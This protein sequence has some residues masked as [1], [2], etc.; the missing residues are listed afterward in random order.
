MLSR[1]PA[2]AEIIIP[3]G[4][5][6]GA[7]YHV[8]NYNGESFPNDITLL[9]A[10]KD[11]V[12]TVYAQAADAVGPSNI[13]AMG[14]S[15]GIQ[16]PLP[17]NMSLVLGTTEVSVLDMAD[18][19]STFMDR[20]TNVSPSVIEEVRDANGKLMEATAPTLT[21]PL[22]ASQADSVT[23]ALQQVVLSGTGTGAQIGR[24]VAGKTGT[25]ESYSD[26]WFIG[27]TPHLT[28]AVWMGYRDAKQPMLNVHGVKNV[29]GGSLPADIFRRFMSGAVV[30]AP[31]NFPR[32]ASLSGNA[33][34]APPVTLVT[35]STSSTSTT[36]SSTSSTSTT[37]TTVA[38]SVTTT[39]RKPGSG[40]G[41]S[42]TSPRVPVT[43][44][45]GQPVSGTGPGP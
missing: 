11:S 45:S 13:V 20:G 17:A 41:P 27:Y 36:S 32:V 33:L 15:L 6:N 34:G 38:K 1:F 42:T 28:A 43:L 23:Y 40:G 21:H 22:T 26:A 3:R 2:P 8:K 35:T 25:T 29:N 19:Y 14:R 24:P 18:A 44:P 10:T 5:K 39:T 30:G 31:E 7:D 37:S 4:D 16:T 9:D 12:N